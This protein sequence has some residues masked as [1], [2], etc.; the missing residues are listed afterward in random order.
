MEG[1]MYIVG[2]RSGYEIIMIVQNKLYLI[3]IITS[4]N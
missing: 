3:L 1:E 2:L 4:R